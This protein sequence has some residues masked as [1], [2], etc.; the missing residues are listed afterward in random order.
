ML[1]RDD[2]GAD[3]NVNV[4]LDYSTTTALHYMDVITNQ[5]LTDPRKKEALKGM[6]HSE[7]KELILNIYDDLFTATSTEEF[8]KDMTSVS[9]LL[10]FMES[11]KN[12]VMPLHNKIIVFSAYSVQA[13]KMFD[14][15]IHRFVLEK[16]RQLN[17][18]FSETYRYPIIM[19]SLSSIK[20]GQATEETQQ[21]VDTEKNAW[22]LNSTFLSEKMDMHPIIPTDMES[23]IYIY[24]RVLLPT[25]DVTATTIDKNKIERSEK[26]GELR[27]GLLRRWANRLIINLEGVKK[28]QDKILAHV[29]KVGKV[30]EEDT[31]LMSIQIDMINYCVEGLKKYV[32]SRP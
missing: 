12:K 29:K 27:R 15:L 8:L 26:A 23:L 30:S 1:S 19:D 16:D 11:D 18:L 13:L 17:S 7:A 5:T 2:N 10:S 24:G 6:N 4:K 20:L 21:K 22:T 32:Q 14:Q 28:S 25:N 31:D 3:S 9:E